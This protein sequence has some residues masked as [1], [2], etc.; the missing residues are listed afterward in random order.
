MTVLLSSTAQQASDKG[1]KL[2]ICI[3]FKDYSILTLKSDSW[4]NLTK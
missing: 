3:I 4:L 2:I 1:I